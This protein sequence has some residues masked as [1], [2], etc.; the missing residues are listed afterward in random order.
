MCLALTN[1]PTT[2]L[3]KEISNS[4]VN[5]EKED[6]HPRPIILR[7]SFF[8]SGDNLY[9]IGPNIFLQ[10]KKKIVREKDFQR[11]DESSGLNRKRKEKKSRV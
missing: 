4:N 3:P 5:E 10:G 8:L 11:F 9:R 6:F 2:L 1:D 7:S